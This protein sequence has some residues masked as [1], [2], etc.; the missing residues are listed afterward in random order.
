MKLSEIQGTIAG[1]LKAYVP[2]A[3]VTVVVDD[4]SYSSGPVQQ[5]DDALSLAT[6]DPVGIS[7]KGLCL[8]VYRIE[9]NNTIGF[10]AAVYASSVLCGVII[11]E[12]ATVNRGEYGT[13]VTLEDAVEHV[14]AAVLTLRNDSG[15]DTHTVFQPG[16]PPWSPTTVI[17]GRRKTIIDFVTNHEIVM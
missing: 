17:N 11:E 16:D 4:G 12:V 14:M 10:D 3:G 6:N 9:H 13:G 8:I 7:K 5:V 2:L 1:L 15:G